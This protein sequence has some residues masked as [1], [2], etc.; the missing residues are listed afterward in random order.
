[1]KRH[2]GVREGG[3][4][5]QNLLPRAASARRCVLIRALSSFSPALRALLLLC[6]HCAGSASERGGCSGSSCASRHTVAVENRSRRRGRPRGRRSCPSGQLVGLQEE[7]RRRRR[8]RGVPFGVLRGCKPPGDKG[9][10]PTAGSGRTTRRWAFPPSRPFLRGTM[11][12]KRAR[13]R[14]SPGTAGTAPAARNYLA[15]LRSACLGPWFVF[16]VARARP[17]R[18]VALW[19]APPKPFALVQAE[20]RRQGNGQHDEHEPKPEHPK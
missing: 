9:P 3:R 4:S 2:F 18:P 14:I 12:T 19:N 8:T 5:S 20:T 11:R 17:S 7:Q 1:M 16:F 13:H 15:G 10:S 6:L